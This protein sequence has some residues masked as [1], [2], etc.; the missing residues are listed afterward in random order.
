[1]L[2]LEMV[3]SLA[4]FFGW[5][6]CAWHMRQTGVQW[7]L[8]LLAASFLINFF[9]LFS[10]RDWPFPAR[11]TAEFFTNLCSAAVA[12]TVAFRMDWDRSPFR[13]GRERHGPF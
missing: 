13:R 6:G 7:L 9:T 2:Y 5:W 1:M 11:E 10:M 3:V 4:A 8:S 12:L